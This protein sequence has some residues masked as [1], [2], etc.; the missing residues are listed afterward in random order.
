MSKVD[1]NNATDRVFRSMHSA[2]DTATRK[3]VEEIEPYCESTIEAMIGAAFILAFRIEE[4]SSD[5]PLLKLTTQ[6]RVEQCREWLLVIVPQYQWREYRIDWAIYARRFNPPL[7]FIECDG[8]DFHE[9]TKEQAERDRSK[10]RAFQEAGI[11]ILRFTGRE[12][13]RDPQNCAAQII[14][15][16]NARAEIT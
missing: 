2:F 14:N 7:F 6:D 8:H 15:F 11:P 3:I 12:I 10:D 5:E 9:R 13:Y 4:F 16:I 1:I